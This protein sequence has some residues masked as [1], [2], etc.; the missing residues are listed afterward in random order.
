MS[1]HKTIVYVGLA[2][3]GYWL[4]T[5][6]QAAAATPYPA[7][8]GT[9]VVTN[10]SVPLPSTSQVST[11]PP[12]VIG[13]SLVPTG[14]NVPPLTTS[15]SIIPAALGPATAGPGAT[16]VNTSPTTGY[17]PTPTPAPILLAPT[18]AADAPADSSLVPNLPLG[19]SNNMRS[20]WPDAPVPLSYLG[21]DPN[22]FA[23]GKPDKMYQT[24]TPRGYSNAKIVRGLTAL[25]L[26]SPH[27]AASIVSLPAP[28][29]DQIY[30][31]TL[32]EYTPEYIRQNS[33]QPSTNIGS[34]VALFSS[35]LDQAKL[36]Q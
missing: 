31:S 12:V 19:Y 21:I 34:N 18:P 2:A 8:T 27:D 30:Q 35:M 32:A 22:H 20:V 26:F 16:Y 7:P 6:N 25:N 29:P 33:A 11:T 13:T 15:T 4:Y 9:T 10:A 36:V 23:A 1:E 17:I 14:S 3:F 28:L 24:L 5:K